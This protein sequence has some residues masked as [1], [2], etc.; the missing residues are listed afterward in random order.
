MFY[1]L[2]YICIIECQIPVIIARRQSVSNRV[3][4]IGIARE[5]SKL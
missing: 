3:T 5:A 4:K 2:S 1:N